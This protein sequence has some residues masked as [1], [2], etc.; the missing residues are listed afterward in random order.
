M[1][2]ILHRLYNVDVFQ[3][4]TPVLTLAL[5]AP[6]NKFVPTT[7][8]LHRLRQNSCQCKKR[9][10]GDAP[11]R[12]TRCLLCGWCKISS[13]H[14]LDVLGE[15]IQAMCPRVTHVDRTTNTSGEICLLPEGSV[16][17]GLKAGQ[18]AE[19]LPLPLR[20]PHLLQSAWA[21]CVA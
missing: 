5:K 21:V 7:E 20:S 10:C 18:G 15:N 17:V 4:R 12:H 13:I 8:I 9:G 14:R 1:E 19:A 3:P 16:T 6:G 11:S 2:E